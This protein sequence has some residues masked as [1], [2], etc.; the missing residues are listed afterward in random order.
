MRMAPNT[1]TK[2]VSKSL[3]T[4]AKLL[5]V[6]AIDLDWKQFGL[7]KLNPLARVS[8]IFHFGV[9]I[10]VRPDWPVKSGSVGT[11]WEKLAI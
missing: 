8:E 4:S 9:K 10:I 11:F 2:L 5:L 6:R 1:G 7:W 3:H